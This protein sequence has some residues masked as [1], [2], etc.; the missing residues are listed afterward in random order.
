MVPMDP[1][2][3]RKPEGRSL[4]SLF[5]LP[6]LHAAPLLLGQHLVRLTED[7]EIR[8]RIVET[9]SYGG[10]EDKGS[11][12]YGGRRTDR[13]DAMFRAGGTAYVYLIY[14]MHHCFNIV[15]A[16]ENDPHA[17]LVRAVE[18]LSPRDARLM[19]ANRGTAIRRP[20]DLSGGPGKLCRALRIDRSLN[21][22]RLD[23]PG[24]PLRL[25][26]GDD[27][28]RLPIVQAPRIN[29]AYAEEYAALPWRF[30]IRDNP[31]VSV[32]DSKAEPFVWPIESN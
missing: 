24:G 6:A 9:E 8:C 12:A 16:E 27:P 30:Y 25:E 13:T 17:V 26:S 5:A 28:R 11:H 2:D 15:T 23:Q 14:G 1:Y 10:A 3:C 4:S 32:H 19:A 7:G 29:I 31:Y 21:G 18:P 22:L 20:S